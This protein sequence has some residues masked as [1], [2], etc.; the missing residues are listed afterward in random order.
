MGFVGEHGS[1]IHLLPFVAPAKEVSTVAVQRAATVPVAEEMGGAGAFLNLQVIAGVKYPGIGTIE[2]LMQLVLVFQERP[3]ER[4]I[5]K[6][7][8]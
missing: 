6:G 8:R 1:Q 4:R 3:E 5:R 2:T 7:Q